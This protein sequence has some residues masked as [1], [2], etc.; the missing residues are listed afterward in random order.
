M[1]MWHVY[2]PDA[3]YTAQERQ[4][5]A[6]GSFLGDRGLHWEIHIDDTPFEFWTIDGYFPPAPESADERRLA[7]ENR[8]SPLVGT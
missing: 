8:P 6:W 3:T 2:N 7:A 5:F 1:P 4:E